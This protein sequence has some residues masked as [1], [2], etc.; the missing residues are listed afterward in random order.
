MNPVRLLKTKP[1]YP[2]ANF[3]MMARPYVTGNGIFDN[4]TVTG[5]LHYHIPNSSTSFKKLAVYKPKLPPLRDTSFVTNFTTKLKS[6]G[7]TEY[8]VNVPKH[9]YKHLFFTVEL[10]T[11]PCPEKQTC[12]GPSHSTMFAAAYLKYFI[13]EENHTLLKYWVVD[14]HILLGE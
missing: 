14:L 2:N 13:C 6:L 1:Y 4:S 5:I 7:N 11:N 3:L 10:G 9:V 8:P 12:Q